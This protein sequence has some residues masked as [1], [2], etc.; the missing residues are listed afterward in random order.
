MKL[1]THILKFIKHGDFKC[2][3]QDGKIIAVE[4]SIGEKKNTITLEDL[5]D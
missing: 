5:K 4:F 2:K 1:I 3:V